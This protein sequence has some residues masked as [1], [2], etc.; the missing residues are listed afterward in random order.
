MN[1]I[2]ILLAQTTPEGR[3]FGLDAQTLIQIA[4][5]LFNA[6]LLAVALTFIL[7]KPVKEFLRKRSETIQGGIED[8]ETTMARANELITS[9]EAKIEEIDQ[10][11]VR[12]LEETQLKAKKDHKIILDEARQEAEAIKKRAMESV[13]QDKLRFHEEM[14]L[15]VIDLSAYMAEKYITEKMDDDAQDRYFNQ[16]IGHLEETTWPS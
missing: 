4:I 9:Y 14:R 3:V 11:R 16:V 8:A 12:I 10:E 13:A 6:I 2:I 5:Q 15:H 7:Y 1:D